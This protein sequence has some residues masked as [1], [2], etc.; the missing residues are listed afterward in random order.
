MMLR[1][2]LPRSAHVA[3]VGLEHLATAALSRTGMVTPRTIQRLRA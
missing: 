3:E 2:A 1:D